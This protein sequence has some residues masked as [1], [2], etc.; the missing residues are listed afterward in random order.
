[1]TPEQF[2]FWLS[3]YLTACNDDDII[4]T[5][6]IILTIKDAIKTVKNGSMTGGIFLKM[7]ENDGGVNFDE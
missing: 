2:V 3:G 7:S 6:H 1:M 4:S 5:N